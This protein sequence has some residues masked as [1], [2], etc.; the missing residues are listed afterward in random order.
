MRLQKLIC[1]DD[2]PIPTL[3][4]SKNVLL[5]GIGETVTAV[6]FLERVTVISKNMAFAQITGG[7]S[8]ETIQLICRNQPEL[9]AQLQCIPIGSSISI[10]GVLGEKEK[11]KSKKGKVTGDSG[12]PRSTALYMDEAE[13]HLQEL[14]CI[15]SFPVD[16]TISPKG[17]DDSYGPENRDLMIRYNKG[18][19]EDLDFRSDVS[20]FIRDQLKDF[21]EI[22]TPILFKSTPEGARACRCRRRV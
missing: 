19:R 5:S 17:R 12:H 18:L 11:P 1:I 15:N 7:H 13:I 8:R 2:A 10:T 4:F 22:E 20:A 14:R 3:R 6:G 21:Q 16:S 9:H